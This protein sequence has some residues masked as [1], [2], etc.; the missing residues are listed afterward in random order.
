MIKKKFFNNEIS[1]DVVKDHGINNN[2]FQEIKKILNRVPNI[3]ELGIFSAMWNEHCSYKSSKKWLRKLH[4]SGPQVVCGPGENAGIIDIGDDEVLIFKME[5][6][7]HPSYI[8]PFQGAATGVGGILR[9]IFT[10]GARPIAVM[11]SLSFGEASLLKTKNLIN[12]VVEGIGNYGNCFGVPNISGELRFDSSYNGNCLVNAFAAGIT[13][14][15]KIF[16]SK[17]SGV[18]MPIVYLGAKTGRDGVG[19]AS[20]ASAEF[21]FNLDEKKPTVQVGDP[22]T[23]KILME[24]CLELMD[25][26]AIISIQDMGAAG[27]TCSSVEMGDKGNLGIELNL[28]NVPTREKNMTAYEL[29]LSESQERMLMVLNPEYEEIAKEIFSKWDLEFS[30]IGKTLKEDRFIIY[31]KSK[32]MAE[33][34]LKSLSGNAPEYDRNWIRKK[35]NKKVIKIPEIDCL[36]ALKT[37]LTSPNFSSRKSVWEQYDHTILANTIIA[38][39]SD[40]GVVKL[41]NGIKALAFTSDVNPFYCYENPYEGGKQAVAEAFRNLISVGSKPLAITDNLNF[42]NP[43]KPEVMGELVECIKGISAASKILNMPVVSGNVSLY[44]ETD[45]NSIK[46]TPTIGAVGIIKNYKDTI[47]MNLKPNDEILLIGKCK[48]NHL[49]Q[50]AFLREVLND[51][52]GLAPNVNL[53]EEYKIGNFI[54]SL[55]KNKLLNGVHDV[56]DGG[57]ALAAAEMALKNKLGVILHNNKLEWFFSEDQARYLISCNKTNTNK[58]FDQGKKSKIEIRII[59]KVKGEYF[60]LNDKKI[61]INKLRKMF[62]TP[63]KKILK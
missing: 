17:A 29:M 37:I 11:N 5:S 60:K 34:P 35:R 43:E 38:P 20:M 21:D 54:L 44:N 56:S 63:L 24:A 32:K 50:S 46:P 18:N 48:S 61:K 49:G 57:I 58:I 6:H 15:N 33:I 25:T 39:G 10:M 52:S 42:G 19:G 26:G 23:E 47:Q 59:G 9:D 22:F 2:E 36:E 31:H 8:E 40:A 7:N 28:D 16:F 53:K 41:N 12:R 14:R 27:L 13:K 1:D 3:T 4:T 45:G 51:N 55:N 62:E 30:I